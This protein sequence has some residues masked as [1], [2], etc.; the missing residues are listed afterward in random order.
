MLSWGT[1]RRGE[2]GHG[3]D[4]E[5]MRTPCVIRALRGNSVRAV[6]AGASHV[7]CVTLQGEVGGDLCPTKVVRD[8]RLE[9]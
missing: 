5:E 7:L 3:A 8:P 1:G 2:L 4:V 9:E 6:V